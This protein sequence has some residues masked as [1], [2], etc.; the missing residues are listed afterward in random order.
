[1]YHHHS[2][3]TASIDRNYP[4]QQLGVQAL[5]HSRS[6]SQQQLQPLPPT[7]NEESL[8]QRI[9][10]LEHKNRDLESETQQHGSRITALRQNHS[11]FVDSLKASHSA[12]L[13]ASRGLAHWVAVVEGKEREINGL[14]GKGEGLQAMICELEALLKA[15]DDEIVWIKKK[16]QADKASSMEEDE[17]RIVAMDL[18]DIG[19]RLIEETRQ[20]KGIERT[21]EEMKTA[22]RDFE[23]LLSE[24]KHHRS[25]LQ[26][27]LKEDLDYH[28]QEEEKRR[29]ELKWIY[30]DQLEK[31]ES[32]RNNERQEYDSHLRALRQEKEEAEHKLKETTDE[33]ETRK[34]SVVTH[35]SGNEELVA[36]LQKINARLAEEKR[37]NKHLES[38]MSK[39]T[40]EA[41]F[42]VS[43]S[44]HDIQKLKNALEDKE[45]LVTNLEFE[46][47]VTKRE[48]SEFEEAWRGLQSECTL[49]EQALADRD[50]RIKDLE[51]ESG[52]LLDGLRRSESELSRQQQSRQQPRQH[53]SR[54][55]R[56]R[57]GNRSKEQNS[58]QSDAQVETSGDS[59]REG[60][61]SSGDD[62]TKDDLLDIISKLRRDIKLYRSDIRAYKHDVRDRDRT[63]Q[64]LSSQL[65]SPNPN[66]I[67]QDD[68]TGSAL[69][70]NERLKAQ[71][72]EVRVV[73]KQ[74]MVVLADMEER[75]KKLRD[76]KETFEANALKQFQR[77]QQSYSRLEKQRVA[78]STADIRACEHPTSLR[79]ENVP[80]GRRRNAVAAANSVRPSSPPPPPPPSKSPI[81][82]GGEQGETFVW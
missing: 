28:L 78:G 65:S 7:P 38:S 21:L 25:Q 63:I 57:Q 24:E 44:K 43:D 40:E 53:H 51:F 20:R 14:R 35:R 46:L 31:L 42:N 27:N 81:L 12:E 45:T 79:L 16:M 71:L 11:A 68:S 13:D 8:L 54:Q 61:L 17:R 34:L 3:Q 56:S 59:S 23:V 73:A 47:S 19:R 49:L 29:E 33:L 1:M 9:R 22:P 70:E 80:N 55:H 6:F 41:W 82:A 69:V 48:R 32:I 50:E 26:H 36:M 10:E 39:I 15:R 4:G 74:K 72:D 2:R 30:G 75:M 64:Q 5:S 37:K 66:L 18:P 77:M 76:E 62:T 67:L 60:V 52:E 58:E